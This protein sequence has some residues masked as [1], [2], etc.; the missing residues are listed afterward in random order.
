[1]FWFAET[2]LR[3][4]EISTSSTASNSFDSLIPKMGTIGE[5]RTEAIKEK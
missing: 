4:G 1:M 2:P 3:L 5:G